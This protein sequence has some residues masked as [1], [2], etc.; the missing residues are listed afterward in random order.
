MSDTNQLPTPFLSSP[1]ASLVR[2]ALLLAVLVVAGFASLTRADEFV[3]R[4]NALYADVRADRRSDPIILAALADLEEPPAFLDSQRGAAALPGQRLGVGAGRGLG[5]RALAGRAARSGSTASPKSRTP[6]RMLVF[7]QPY[8]LAELGS[9]SAQIEFIQAGLYTDLGDPPL[10]AAAQHLYLKQFDH[11]ARLV[12]VEAT[13]RLA[14]GDPAGSLEVLADLIQF[15]RQILDREFHAEK[16]WAITTMSLASERMRDVAYNDMRS[17][18][19]LTPAQ[20]TESIERLVD[21]RGPISIG[22]IRLPKGDFIAAEQLIA[23]VMERRGSIRTELFASTMA[24]LESTERPLRLFGEAARWRDAAQSHVNWTGANQMLEALRGDF[25]FRWTLSPFDPL[26]AQ[27]FTIESVLENSFARDRLAVVSRSIPDMR[28]LFAQRQILRTE[29]LG[30]Q[31]ALGLA[32]FHAQNQRYP[33]DL[34]GIRPQYIKDVG[35]DPFN[36]SVAEGR[37]PPLVFFVP[38]RDTADRFANQP[39]TPPHV[40]SILVPDAPNVSISLRADQF[41]LFSVGADGSGQWADE[42]Q[43]TYNAPPGRD[44]LIWPPVMS[45]VR[46]T[47]RDSG[48]FN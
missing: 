11:L 15:G 13:R 23:T 33:L 29:I 47:L 1:R 10:L 16:M 41:V 22:R 46:D 44:Y 9:D 37:Q 18:G 42:A 2:A 5:D 12:H 45:V 39:N 3:D 36:P 14:E 26:M 4:V 27:A 17:G 40:I 7:A 20:L 35:I 43:N 19:K 30:T 21:D 6:R 38:V 31:N 24:R 8:G 32:A 48:A 28:E 34:S 25:E